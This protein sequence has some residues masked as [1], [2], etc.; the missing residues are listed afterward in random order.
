[1]EIP[2][3]GDVG[4]LG[5]TEA[6]TPVSESRYQNLTLPATAATEIIAVSKPK[7]RE[8]MLSSL[9]TNGNRDGITQKGEIQ[10]LEALV[11]GL[12]GLE[13]PLELRD[14]LLAL[15]AGVL[16]VAFAAVTLVLALTADVGFSVPWAMAALAISA[17]VA[18]RQS[19][20][21]SSRAEISVSAL[22][23]VLA[24]VIYGP[25]AAICVSAISLL[26]NLGRPYG[27]WIT[28]TSARSLAAGAAG[29]MAMHVDGS[30]PSHVF[31]RVLAAVAIATLIEQVGDLLLGSVAAVL[32][33]V[34]RSE[35]FRA[36]Q[37]MFLAMP[38]YIPVAALLAFTYRAVSPWSVVLFLFPALV[39]QKLF[40]LY[41]EQRATSEALAEV[42]SH[43]KRA[44]L[45]FASAM[46][47]TLDAR[48]EYTA[49]HS[50]AVAEYARDIAERMGLS[51]E[52][53]RLAHLAGLVHDIGKIGLPPGLLEK[54][55]PLTRSERSQM[56]E[57]PMI[58]ERILA[59]VEDYAEIALIVRHHHERVDG[60]GYPD[61][62]LGSEI[63]LV[64][65]IIAVA[66]AYNAMTSDR[67]YR[68]AMPSRVARMRMAQAVD[69]QFD[70]A[71]VAAFE[72][73]LVGA[74]D[75]YRTGDCFGTRKDPKELAWVLT[76]AV[77]AAH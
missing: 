50:T 28:W 56:E 8:R 12:F 49:G 70:T 58:A 61:R 73:V 29:L 7:I 10:G 65:R 55:G 44:H 36:A 52:E 60:N 76:S 18:E 37:T 64:S 24:A 72:A 63:P 15:Y 62:L 75:R 69:S 9:G 14:W 42:L 77:A 13:A 20:R 27:R 57:H 11:S 31:G 39:A 43:Q 54:P 16:G 26:P 17:V 45:S 19:V 1:V 47:A 25:L 40:L 51:D 46:V 6:T 2:Q 74:S 71:V 67:P 68:D 23:I 33:K 53:Q 22:P 34:P 66:D 35:I 38:L 30:T 41:Q 4:N 21:L 48:D 5:K 59:K 3:Q 32:R